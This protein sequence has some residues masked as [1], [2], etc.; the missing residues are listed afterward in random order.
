MNDHWIYADF[1]PQVDSFRSFFE[2]ELLDI[3]QKLVLLATYY[4][5]ER[6]F[7][8]NKSTVKYDPRIGRP[9]PYLVFWF[10]D[11]LQLGNEEIV[12]QLALSLYYI[13]IVVSLKDDL[14]DGRV[15]LHGERV[16]E[17]CY[18]A[19]TNYFYQKYYEIFTKYLPRQSIFW[20]I[21]TESLNQWF[22]YETWSFLFERTDKLS[23][24]S[25]SYLRASSRYLVAITYPTIAAIALLTKRHSKL[26]VLKDFL[27]NYCMG[28]KVVDDLRDWRKDFNILNY[29]HSTIIYQ[30]MNF[31]DSGSQVDPCLTESMFLHKP[32]I[33][34]IYESILKNF[35]NAKNDVSSLKSKYLNEFIGTQKDFYRAERDSLLKA[36]ETM[37]SSLSALTRK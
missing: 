29:N 7:I 26:A 10:S 4:L 32:F 37:M 5:K 22:D 12:N 17:H 19:L 20:S 16:N 33:V 30:A 9:V 15:T 3:P 35:A 23:P 31:V 27:T 18:V 11:A 21:L 8:V 25:S 6:L 14:V 1:K 13:S 2:R 34:P 24:L 28:W 36:I